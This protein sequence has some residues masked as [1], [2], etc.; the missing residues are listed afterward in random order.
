MKLLKYFRSVITMLCCVTL[1]VVS[2]EKV[3][4]I[5]ILSP[6]I[7]GSHGT[8]SVNKRLSIYNVSGTLTKKR[9]LPLTTLPFGE[10]ITNS[11]G[12]W[13]WQQH[14]H[15]LWGTQAG[16][17]VTGGKKDSLREVKS[18]LRPGR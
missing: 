7:Q 14:R 13:V 8:Y 17:P 12:A 2:L 15:E 3:I 1:L 5:E 16:Q 18:D 6:Q 10:G 11:W 4:E 9:A